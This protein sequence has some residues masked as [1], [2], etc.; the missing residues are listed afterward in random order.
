MIAFTAPSPDAATIATNL[1]RLMARD[2]LTYDDVVAATGLDE[3]T[4]RALVRCKNTPHARTLNKLAAGLGVPVEEL[5]RPI[6]RSPALEF[7]RATN[8][9]VEEVVAQH[10]EPFSGWTDAEFSELY[11]RFGTGGALTETGIL[12]T[13]DAMNAK[14]TVL[15]QVSLILESGEATALREYVAFLYERATESGATNNREA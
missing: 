11:S 10:P 15:D 3:R 2:G 8:A 6:P 7:D 9:L 1:R 13:A 14:R 5:F 12:T 4:V